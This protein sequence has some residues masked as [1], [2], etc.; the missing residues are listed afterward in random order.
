ML[1]NRNSCGTLHAIFA[2]LVS[3][4]GVHCK[5]NVVIMPCWNVTHITLYFNNLLITTRCILIKIMTSCSKEDFLFSIIFMFIHFALCPYK[6]NTTYIS[7]AG[8]CKTTAA[9]CKEF[10]RCFFITYRQV[11]MFYLW[12]FS[13][14]TNTIVTNKLSDK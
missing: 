11:Y 2:C 14:L 13:R 3:L 8:E 6:P 1:I 5:N 7:P 10:E 9:Q 4:F 12:K